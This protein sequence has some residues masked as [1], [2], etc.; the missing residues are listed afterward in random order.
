M[1]KKNII[2]TLIFLLLCVAGII[3]SEKYDKPDPVLLVQSSLVTVD[4]PHRNIPTW[5]KTVQDL[6]NIDLP[7][8]FPNNFIVKG[9]TTEAVDDV[10]SL[11]YFTVVDKEGKSICKMKW[12]VDY[13][14]KRVVYITGDIE[15]YKS[16]F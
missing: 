14:S 2:L 13:D 7:E 1:K 5:G 11:V 12:R 16:H 4:T 3:Y 8:K 10:I 9:W 15:L 6:I